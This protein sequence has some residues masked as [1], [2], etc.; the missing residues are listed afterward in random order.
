MCEE[1]VD[2]EE[3]FQLW[4]F[5]HM[6]TVAADHRLQARHR[7]LLRRRLPARRAGPHVLPGAARRAHR[8]RALSVV[9][10]PLPAVDE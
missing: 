9:T 2:V 4:R 7:R 5:R 1:L 3:S 10:C 8:D 6:K